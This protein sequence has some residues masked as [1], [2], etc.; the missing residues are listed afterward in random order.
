[1][2]AIGRQQW[3]N[4]DVMAMGGQH[5]AECLQVLCHPLEATIN[6]CGQ[7]GGEETRERGDLGG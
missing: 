4:D 5:H 2:T 7:F 3:D 1:M 6:Q